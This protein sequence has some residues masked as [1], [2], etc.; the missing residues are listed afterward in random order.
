MATT[1]FS[2][3]SI[4]RKVFMALTGFFLMF[5]L[6]QHL[7]IN[8]LSVISPDMFNDVSHFMGTNPIVQIALQPVLIFA[9]IAHFIMGIV[10]D[11]KNRN[12]REVSYAK[13]NANANSTWM[14]RNMIISGL[15]IL[16]FLVLHFVDFWF[17]E[18]SVKYIQ[19][20]MSGL[21]NPDIA[22]S[23]YRYYEELHH[24]F[25]SLPHV[26]AYV[27][28]FVLLALHLQH[29]FSSAFQSVGARNNNN[30][31]KLQQFGN[32]FAVLVPLGFVA[33][34][35]FHFFTQSH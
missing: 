15:T 1:K 3:S 20:D 30:K 25:S 21:I 4:G 35:L 18:M 31:T 19:G 9:V 5:F 12:A 8:M 28:S 27:V 13:N 7:T 14:S 11:I 17:H 34:A 16:A 10:L 29:G 22:E 23:G 2:K 6:L 33:I 32:A 24:K 26:I